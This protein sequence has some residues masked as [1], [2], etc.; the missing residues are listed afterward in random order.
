MLI[1]S[2]VLLSE[3]LNVLHII[4]WF[5]NAYFS[6]NPSISQKTIDMIHDIS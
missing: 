3:F 4:D 1:F 5:T 6:R 2:R